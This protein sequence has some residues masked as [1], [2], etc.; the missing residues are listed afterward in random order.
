M[1]GESERPKRRL[2]L[3]G[4]GS[5][6]SPSAKPSSN[7]PD[8]QRPLQEDEEPLPR[9][10]WHWTAIGVVAIYLVW[11]P[12]AGLINSFVMKTFFD[13]MDSTM[14][15]YAPLSSRVILIGLNAIAFIL[16]AFAGGYLVGRFGKGAGHREATLCGVVAAGLAWALAYAPS[17]SGSVLIWGLLLICM[18]GM[19]ALGAY[20][21]ARAGRRGI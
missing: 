17:P 15:H 10:P 21:G 7:N 18:L 2:P 1:T 13:G 19:G 4:Q 8:P 3:V 11:L 20:G 12:L 5:G 9:P 14:L 6:E 16:S